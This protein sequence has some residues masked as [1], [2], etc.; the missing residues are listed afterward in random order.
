METIYARVFFF[1]V[2]SI[3]CLQ[4][5][6]LSKDNEAMEND[7]SQNARGGKKDHFLRA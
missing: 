5:A 3:S 2:S 1:D 4:R 6:M 7:G